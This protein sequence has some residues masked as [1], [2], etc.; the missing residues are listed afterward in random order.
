MWSIIY[1]VSD[2]PTVLLLFY[3]ARVWEWDS[4]PIYHLGPSLYLEK[5]KK[6]V[7]RI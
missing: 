3:G 6:K 5:K 7:W 2:G 4:N 1:R